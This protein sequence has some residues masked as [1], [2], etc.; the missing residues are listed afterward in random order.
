[1]SHSLANHKFFILTDSLL[2]KALLVTKLIQ[3]HTHSPVWLLVKKES[4]PRWRTWT[5]KSFHRARVS[6]ECVSPPRGSPL[7]HPSSA[8]G[9]LSF[10]TSVSAI[11]A[12]SF[13]GLTEDPKTC[14]ME[15]LPG[16]SHTLG[17]PHSP[18]TPRVTPGRTSRSCWEGSWSL[19]WFPLGEKLLQTSPHKT[20]PHLWPLETKQILQRAFF[21]DP[22]PATG[23]PP[24]LFSRNP[25]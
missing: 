17:H 2:T 7:H 18:A 15:G 23:A 1:M 22:H 25:E 12:D 16:L 5:S 9:F 6:S 20:G 3:C 24:T 11:T 14:L 13:S 19:K 21:T 4:R 8:S 10:F